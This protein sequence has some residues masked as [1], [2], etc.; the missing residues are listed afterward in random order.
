M[1]KTRGISA[2]F[3]RSTTGCRLLSKIQAE[4]GVP[5][6]VPIRDKDVRWNST[7]DSWSWF[8]RNREALSLYNTRRKGEAENVVDNPDGTCYGDH[9]LS[10]GD[11]ELIVQ[12][13]RICEKKKKIA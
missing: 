4:L 6:T 10:D 1:K 8:V 2:H 12:W 9:Q 11:W 7:H 3:R 13:V 5:V